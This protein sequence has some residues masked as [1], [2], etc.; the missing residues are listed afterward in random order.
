MSQGSDG[1]L[2]VLFILFFRPIRLHPPVLVMGRRQRYVPAMNTAPAVAPSGPRAAFASPDFRKYQVSRFLLTLA[3]QM[4]SVAVGW[5]VYTLTGHALDLG[6]VGL[7]QF[8]PAILLSLVTGDTADRFDRRRILLVCYALLTLCALLFWS[9][10]TMGVS[11][12]GPLYAVLVLLG[13]ARAFAGPASQSLVAHLVPTEH[14]SSALALNSSIWQVAT[15]IGPALGGL[16]YD[17]TH[18]SGVY[19]TCTALLALSSVFLANMEVRTGRLEQGS[20]SWE[21]LVAGLHY[22]WRKK[23]LL[24]AISMDLFAVL[25]GGAVALLPIMA[26]DILHTGPWGLGLLRSAPAVGAAAMAFALSFFPL[27]RQAGTV[28]FASVAVFGLATVGFGL[29]RHLALSL[30]CLG[31]LGAAD[32]VS[33]VIRSTLVQLATPA[34]M[35]G[36]VSAV[37]MVFIGASNELGDFESGLTAEWWGAPRAVVVGG[38]GTLL[39]VA[40][41][42]WGFPELRRV[43]RVDGVSSAS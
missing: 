29:S 33:V 17:A 8:L 12:V 13:V 20:R 5:H 23:V 1:R 21:R 4:Q 9:L 6:Y 42:A 22:V 26:Q 7:A 10:A 16:L 37:N 34:E 36:R 39:V 25:L 32:M 30:A 15:I 3:V 28:M 31:V 11:R 18:A 24:G 27:R 40:A 38:V 2:L 14:L 41:W 43:A 35:R 19:A